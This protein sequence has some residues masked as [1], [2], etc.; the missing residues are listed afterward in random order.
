[1]SVLLGYWLLFAL[2]LWLQLCM[3]KW[4]SSSEKVTGRSFYSKAR[5]F[6]WEPFREAEMS[7]WTLPGW[8]GH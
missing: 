7:V 8:G 6:G 3:A 1:V 5:N 2:L 4:L